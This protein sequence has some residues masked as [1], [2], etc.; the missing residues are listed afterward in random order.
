MA[1]RHF[2]IER[3]ADGSESITVH[4]RGM[5]VLNNPQINRGPGFTLEE[6]SDL[7]LHGM[8][9]TAVESLEEQLVRSYSEFLAFE[10][11]IEKWVF[12]TGV[13]DTNEV[14]FYALLGEH[15]E[16]MLPIVYTP[17]VGTAIEQFSHMFRRPR[18]V[19]LNVKN[20][21]DIDRCLAATGLEAED[22]D[23]IVASDAE[24]ILGIGDWGVGGIDIAIGKLAVYTV[25]AGIDP[26]RVLAVGL[27]VGTNREALL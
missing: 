25:A 21:A 15:I 18:G 13:Q 6:R 11:D 19:Y 1:S 17:T 12:L 26:R 4:A 23:L 10:T 20:T 16:E 9:P 8:L 5:D 24:A 27:D 3:G 7:G 2:S 14:L 22:V